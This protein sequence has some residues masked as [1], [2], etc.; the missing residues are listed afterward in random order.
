ME[1]AEAWVE[2]F[3][4][5]VILLKACRSLAL[6]PSQACCSRSHR[7]GRWTIQAPVSDSHP[8]CCTPHPCAPV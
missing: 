2:Y 3:S 8:I 7:F 6:G 1:I 4:Q 5:G